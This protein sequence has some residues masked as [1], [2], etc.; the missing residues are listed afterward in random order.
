MRL[1]DQ[2][3]DRTLSSVYVLLTKA[4]ALQLQSYLAQQLEG[5]DRAPHDHVV[6]SFGHELTIGIFDASDYER[7]GWAKRVVRIIRDDA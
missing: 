4:E 5:V 1:Y 7:A 6:D 3:Q 2:K